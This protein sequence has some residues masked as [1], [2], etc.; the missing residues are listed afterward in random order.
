MCVLAAEKNMFT[1]QKL[2]LQDPRRQYYLSS[3][4][5]CGQKI[6]SKSFKAWLSF[7]GRLRRQPQTVVFV[8]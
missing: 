6:Y 8:E 3:P 1:F 5:K 4:K 7:T 2:R